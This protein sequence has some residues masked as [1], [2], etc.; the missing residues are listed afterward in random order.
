MLSS[1]PS[2]YLVSARY[3][4][5]N[6]RRFGCWT[7]EVS[8]WIWWW[9]CSL[10]F[11]HYLSNKKR[12]QRP[13]AHHFANNGICMNVTVEKWS[14][15]VKGDCSSLPITIAKIQNWIGSWQ[16]TS[17]NDVVVHSFNN[18]LLVALAKMWKY[19]PCRILNTWDVDCQDLNTNL[20]SSSMYVCMLMPYPQ[21]MATMFHSILII[22]LHL[23]CPSISLLG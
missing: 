21:Y 3:Q 16:L 18:C 14:V 8:N 2:I 19:G 7:K 13:S 15:L 10:Y 23:N 4:S 22:G 17:F 5:Y 1:H 9:H 12:K 11:G 6:K 20:F